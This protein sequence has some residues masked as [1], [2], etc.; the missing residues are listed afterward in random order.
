MHPFFRVHYFFRDIIIQVIDLKNISEAVAVFGFGG[1]IYGLVEIF[2][3]GYTHWTMVLTGG[4][5]FTIIYLIN[6]KLRTDSLLPR[7]FLGCLII[8]SAEFAV[9]CIVN[10]TLHWNV[11][12]YSSER[13]NILG[14]ICPLFSVGWFFI[15]IPATFI[16]D[17]LKK[18]L[19]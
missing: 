16:A 5:V 13:F 3:R 11:W 6:L 8:T 17:T 4:I 7:C 1:V 10:L 18:E 14:Q 9:G 19:R 12:D 2:F 15:C